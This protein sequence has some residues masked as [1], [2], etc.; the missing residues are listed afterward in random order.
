MLFKPIESPTYKPSDI[1]FKID[2]DNEDS[3]DELN[4]KRQNI[5]ENLESITNDLKT[6]NNNRNET[7]KRIR[8]TT[9]SFPIGPPITTLDRADLDRLC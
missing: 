8:L 9:P 1:P 6:F 2:F 4:V 3:D 7:N 5:Q